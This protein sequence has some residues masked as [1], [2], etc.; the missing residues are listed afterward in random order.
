L[1]TTVVG[2]VAALAIGG[3]SGNVSRGHPSPT[4]DT[5]APNAPPVAGSASSG[6]TAILGHGPTSIDFVNPEHGWIATGCSSY[7]YDSNPGIIRTDNGGRTWQGVHPPD[8]AATSISGSVWYQY[9]GVVEVRFVNPER[10]WYLQAGE[11]WSTSDAGATWRLAHL[12]GVVSTIA[13]SGSGV[14]ALVD[15]C[16]SGALLDCAPFHLYYKA[17]TSPGWQRFPRTLSPGSGLFS[18]SVLVA[19][20]NA[21]L[22]STPGHL[23]NAEP[24][25]KLVDVDASC[26]PIGALAPGQLVGLC[27]SCDAVVGA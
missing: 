14:W 17:N 23:F 11:L 1:T 27:G 19:D 26:Q 20:G 10:G 8:M 7:C 13:T 4:G 22:V 16:P 9:G 25:G 12:G 18:G 3:S 15:S 6:G 21:A 2:L 5:V 24:N